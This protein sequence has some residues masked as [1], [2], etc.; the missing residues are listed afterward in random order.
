[1]SNF[2]AGLAAADTP[3]VFDAPPNIEA[4]VA[5]VEVNDLGEIS[6]APFEG[7]ELMVE[8]AVAAAGFDGADGDEKKEVMEAFAFGFLAALVATSAVLRLSGVAIYS[9]VNGRC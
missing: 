1:L 5:V 6:F 9:G 2:G 8:E 4:V 3:A 7:D